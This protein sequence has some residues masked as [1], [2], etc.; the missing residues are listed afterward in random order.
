MSRSNNRYNK[1]EDKLLL[2]AILGVVLAALIL[3]MPKEPVVKA[4][5]SVGG[6]ASSASGLYLSEIMSDNAS[7][8]PDENG[9]FADWLEVW[10]TSDH[11]IEMKNVGLSNR[12][13]KIQFLFPE[14]TLEP[15]GR[16]I[17]F[18]DKVNRDDPAGTLHAKCKLSSLGCTVFLFDQHGVGLDQVTVPTLNADESYQ[19]VSLHEWRK[20]DE[21]APG[22]EK[23]PEGHIAYLDNFH[24]EADILMIN[25]VMPVPKT[26]LRDEDG[27]FSDWIELYNAGTATLRLSDF[28]LSDN[29]QKPLKWF[30][31]EG[32][33]IEPGQYYIVFC[34]GKN[35]M[36]QNGI[37][38]TNYKLSGEGETIVLSTKAGELID[39][40]TVPNIGKDVSYGKN[41]GTSV[42]SVFQIAT[43]GRPNNPQGMSDADRYMRQ[44][45]E[46]QVYIVEVLASADQVAPA[47][48]EAAC[49]WVE[50]YNAGASPYDL[51]LHG[52]S[53]NIGWPRKWQFPMGTTIYPGEYKIVRCDKSTSS[54]SGQSPHASFGI[55]KSGGE[56][57]TLSDPQGRV[58]DKLYIS[59]MRTDVSYGRSLETNGFFY[60]DV[61]TPGLK[62]GVG[63][64][65][66]SPAPTLSAKGGLYE[67]TLYVTIDVPEGTTV[68]YTTDGSVP[69]LENS[70]VYSVPL[71]FQNSTV[72][73]A[74]SFQS[75]LQPS[76]TVTAS[77]IM[78]TYFTLPVVSVVVDPYDLYNETD[79]LF[80]AGPNLDKSKGIPFRNAIYRQF[81]KIPRP[82][83]IEVFEQNGA[84]TVISQGIKIALGGDYSLDMPQK[85]LKIR[86][87]AKYGEKY[88][89]YPLFEDRPFTY[90]KSFLLR[91]SGNDCVWTRMADGFQSQLIDLLD[92]DIIHLAFKPVIVYINGEYY[93]HYNMR[94]RKDR[95]CIAQWEGLDMEL[96]DQIT[97]LRASYSTVQGSNK[98]YRALLDR[99]KA[100]SPGKNPADLQ[101]ILDNVDVDS[102]Y[103]YLAIEMFFGNSDIGNTMFYRLPG[104]GQKWKWLIFDLDYGM[105]SS[106]FNSPKSYTKPKGMGD[107]LINNTIFLKLLENAEMKQ[108]FLERLAYVYRTLTPQV[109]NDKLT[110]I[111]AI[112][113]PEMP[114]H[115]ERWAPLNDKKINSD[116]PLSKDGA[117][118]YWNTRINRMRDT[119]NR[120]HH[121][122]WQYVKESFNLTN[123]QM[124]ELFGEQP[125]DPL[126]KK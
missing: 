9:A 20:S 10:N 92:T 35:K 110:Q 74:R 67:G 52:L 125:A 66:Y 112:L 54:G 101:Y 71:G 27:E 89:E 83:Y 43:P 32:A 69:T 13:D 31:P 30:F 117:L 4:V 62:N 93:G 91:N 56:T 108:K 12:S 102:Y 84:G 51:S 64:A 45:N 87:Q 36:Q 47:N 15:G 98:E 23:T 65:G 50:L 94:E 55:T 80:T 18:C 2:I 113:E 75:G 96:A 7:A 79:G 126:A 29:E 19:R 63:F 49:D 118:G 37:P 73:R 41:P 111:K 109:M 81:G 17:V 3:L 6:G 82:A 58:L 122:V 114:M 95:F 100:S 90:Y 76:D 5:N 1:K 86:A 33:V 99:V 59:Q 44:I 42:W 77:Y 39:R 38:H 60:Y 57:I 72:L 107:K 119:I 8:L 14:M 25:E 78:N 124:L 21:Y 105:F 116:S 26:G 123:A 121:F 103:D 115:F 28:A 88:F 16:V 48:G 120:R 46:S 106:S 61:P 24:I 70:S 97:I 68:R 22:Y 85:T 11:P 104:P 34:S 53:D 40:V